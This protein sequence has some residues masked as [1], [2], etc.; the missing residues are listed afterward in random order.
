MFILT[1]KNSHT[2]SL[3]L[4]HSHTLTLS[5]THSRTLSPSHSLSP[6][7]PPSLRLPL[8]PGL[9]PFCLQIDICF[10]TSVP[11]KAPQEAETSLRFCSIELSKV[12]HPILFAHP[13]WHLPPNP[14]PQGASEG[15]S[16]HV[17]FM[18]D[19]SFLS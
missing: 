9:H 13:K 16:Y 14:N 4:S 6:S 3:T 1:Y 11:A 17:L 15:G 8:R 19:Y 12:Y 18:M 2:H 5:H 7:L 10:R